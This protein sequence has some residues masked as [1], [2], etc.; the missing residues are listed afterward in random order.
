LEKSIRFEQQS[1]RDLEH[2]GMCLTSA[3]LAYS[4]GT[5]FC[6]WKKRIRFERQSLRDVEHVGM[7]PQL[8]LS[9]LVD[10][11]TS[12]GCNQTKKMN[13]EVRVVLFLLIAFFP[14]IHA[15]LCTVCKS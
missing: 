1:L 5:A 15:C 11:F 4:H 9:V 10:F 13:E 3:G 14:H 6:T 12:L 7:N 8:L 2:V